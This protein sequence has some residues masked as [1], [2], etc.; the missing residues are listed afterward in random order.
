MKHLEALMVL[1]TL[2]LLTVLARPAAPAEF[3]NTPTPTFQFCADPTAEVHTVCMVETAGG[4]A[5]RCQELIG[6]Q[7]VYRAVVTPPMCVDFRVVATSR[8]GASIVLSDPS[9]EYQLSADLDGNGAVGGGD[10]SYLMRHLGIHGARGFGC[11]RRN[12]GQLAPTPV[13]PSP[14]PSCS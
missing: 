1:L 11:F 14:A 5:P 12:F 10:F 4:G 8:R 9:K 3:V 6:G 2:L 13:I 7:A